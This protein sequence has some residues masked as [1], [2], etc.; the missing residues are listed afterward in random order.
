MIFVK[1]IEYTILA[2]YTD[3]SSYYSLHS[4]AS[5]RKKQQKVKSP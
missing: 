1:F 3:K 2:I 4:W 5:G